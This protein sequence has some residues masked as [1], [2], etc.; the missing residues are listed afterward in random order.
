MHW[1]EFARTEGNMVENFWNGLNGPVNNCEGS[2][3]TW[4]TA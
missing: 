3:E 4:Q 1:V 2:E